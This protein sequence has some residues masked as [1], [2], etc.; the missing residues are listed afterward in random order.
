MGQWEVVRF[1]LWG[2]CLNSAG[3]MVACGTLLCSSAAWRLAFMIPI[4]S[5]ESTK[6]L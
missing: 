3:T 4:C 5:N 6:G 2:G 1:W